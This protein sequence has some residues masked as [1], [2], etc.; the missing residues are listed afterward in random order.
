MLVGGRLLP[1]RAESIGRADPALLRAAGPKDLD[2]AEAEGL[3][4]IL[5]LGPATLVVVD[6]DRPVALRVPITN[7]RFSYTPLSGANTGPVRPTGR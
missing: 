6:D 3:A 7:G 5:D 2:T 1:V 4:D